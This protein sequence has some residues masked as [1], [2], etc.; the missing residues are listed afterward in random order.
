MKK[1][2][3]IAVATFLAVGVWTILVYLAFSEGWSRR[4]IAPTGEP[5][6]FMEAAQRKV[7]VANSGN[8]AMVLIEDG[9]VSGSHF[10]SVGE[11][12]RA[13]T[14]FQVASLSKWLAAWGVMHL[15]E[16]GRV[17][18][19]AP[20][21]TY[22][23]RWQ[24]PDGPFDEHQVTVRRLLSHTAGLGDGLGYQGFATEAEVQSIEASLTSAGDA[25]P[26]ADGRVRVTAEPGRGWDYSGGGY[27]LLQLVVEEVT[28]QSFADYMQQEV[29]APMGL[30]D[31]T[32]VFDEAAA[33]DLAQNFDAAG[34]EQPFRRY[35]ALAATSLF[36]SAAD[37][38]RFVMAQSP[39][40]QQ[41]GRQLLSRDTRAAMREPHGSELGADIWGLGTMLYAANGQGDFVIGHDGNNEPAINSAV[42]LN[43]DTGD[44]IVILTTGN[45]LLATELAGE[46][47]FWKTG[48]VDFL[49]FSMMMGTM[50]K[51]IATGAVL[52]IVA[53]VLVGWRTARHR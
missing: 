32:F 38:A 3:L 17:D 49:M 10:A 12:V 1:Y 13:D 52:I 41:T 30:R 43:P 28:G 39:N 51:W 40:P 34:A 16:E 11:P 19:D 36:T 50:L 24:L 5:A 33:R 23:S 18:L 25:S 35:T 21:S 46:W 20:V 9:E 4:A 27:T 53:G 8:V 26:N 45:A 22:L 29:F 15:V 48:N 47:V 37:M 44:G 42:R 6:A 7:A 2:L 31:T 14:L